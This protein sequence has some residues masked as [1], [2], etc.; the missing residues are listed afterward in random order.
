MLLTHLPPGGNVKETIRLIV[1]LL[2][3]VG[4]LAMIVVTSILRNQ[5]GS[6]SALVL[7][8]TGCVCCAMVL[9]AVRWL[10]R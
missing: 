1:E 8:A 4:F 2:L 10:T 3:A 5:L 6:F 9:I 7:G